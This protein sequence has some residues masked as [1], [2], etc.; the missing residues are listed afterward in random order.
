MKIL[1]KGTT[2]DL[3]DIVLED[4][5]GDYP[6]IENQY[7]VA[8]F[9]TAKESMDGYFMPRRGQKFRCA[10]EFKKIEDANKAFYKLLNSIITIHDLTDHLVRPEYIEIM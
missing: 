4:W 7:V 6:T 2:P 8:T 3:I 5:S 9:P 10:F 1:D